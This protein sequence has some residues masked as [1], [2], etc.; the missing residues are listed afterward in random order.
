M[1]IVFTLFAQR[2][3]FYLEKEIYTC[4]LLGCLVVVAI[5]Q[6]S[7]QASA[8]SYYNGVSGWMDTQCKVETVVSSQLEHQYTYSQ[9]HDYDFIY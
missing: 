2:G 9:W 1:L 5:F 8:S 6:F 7:V 3:A 4:V